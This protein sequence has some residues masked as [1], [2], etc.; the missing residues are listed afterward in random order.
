MLA[1]KA[2]IYSLSLAYAQE[3]ADWPVLQSHFEKG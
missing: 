3:A 1:T 2:N